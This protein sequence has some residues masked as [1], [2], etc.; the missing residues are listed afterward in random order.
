MPRFTVIVTRDTTESTTMH[1]VAKTEEEA[2]D[3][4]MRAARNHAE[5]LSW[6]KDFTPNASADPYITLC[7]KE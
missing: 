7:E 3:W 1:I 4:A 6:T 5:A 2:Q